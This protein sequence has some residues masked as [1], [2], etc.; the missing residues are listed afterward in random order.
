MK[1]PDVRKFARSVWTA[2]Q[3]L[4]KTGGVRVAPAIALARQS[5]CR[6]CPHSTTGFFR[7]ESFRQCQIC[8]CLTEPKSQLITETCPKNL[9]PR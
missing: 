1:A 2:L 4:F 7:T 9:W 5:V 3:S 6:A 8:T